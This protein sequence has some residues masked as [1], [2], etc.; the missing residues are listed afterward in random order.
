MTNRDDQSSS[1]PPYTPPDQT[2][3]T[4]NKEA[5]NQQVSLEYAYQNKR[6][7]QTVVTSTPMDETSALARGHTDLTEFKNVNLP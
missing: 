2:T 7:S 3:E 6:A 5:M 1:I 4:T